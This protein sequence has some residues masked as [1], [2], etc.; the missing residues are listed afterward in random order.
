MD[1]FKQ[2][3]KE[4]KR[5]QA[6]RQIMKAYDECNDKSLFPIAV[7]PEIEPVYSTI[8]LSKAF[9]IPRERLR[10]WMVKDFIK[11]SLP[12]TSKGT[13][14][15]FTKNDACRVYLFDVLVDAGLTR[16]AAGKVAK[17]MNLIHRHAIWSMFSDKMSILLNISTRSSYITNDVSKRLSEIT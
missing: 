17:G 5:R 7:S 14:A 15:I 10:D 6:H 2:R 8:D 11:P 4:E 1:T 12:S 3:K 9:D 13:I 16:K